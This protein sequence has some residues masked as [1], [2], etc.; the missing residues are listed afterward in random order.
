MSGERQTAL[1]SLEVIQMVQGLKEADV[2]LQLLKTNVLVR[3]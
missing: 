1:L 3:G 2:D